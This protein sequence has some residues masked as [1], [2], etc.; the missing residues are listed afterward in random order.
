MS[1]AN[2][3]ESELLYRSGRTVVLRVQKSDGRN[4]ITKAPASAFPSSSERD[5]YRREF[6]LLQSW[7]LEGLPKPVE[8]LESDGQIQLVYED[9]QAESLASLLDKRYPFTLKQLTGL[10]I[11]AADILHKLHSKGIVHGDVSPNHLLWSTKLQRLWLIDLKTCWQESNQPSLYGSRNQRQ[12]QFKRR[13]PCRPLFPWDCCL[14]SAG[15]PSPIRT[16]V[17][18][19]GPRPRSIGP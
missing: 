4:L 2:P 13:S 7:Q 16:A 11:Q 18:P 8:L 17:R 3:T 12:D 19:F 14:A 15:G 10:L 1:A 6:S 5:E 9:N